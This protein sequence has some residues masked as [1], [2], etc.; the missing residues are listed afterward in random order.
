MRI[1][2]AT[3]VFPPAIG[4]PAKYAKNIHEELVRRGLERSLPIG[5]RHIIYFLRA[6]P[7]ALRA[8]VIFAL[9]TWS[10]GLPALFLAKILRKKFMVRIGGEFLW[11]KYV[12]RTKEEIRLS[13]FYKEKHPLDFKERVTLQGTR[14]LTRQADA[15]LFTTLWLARIWQEPYGLVSSK[16]HILENEYPAREEGI[17]PRAR[18]FVY[19]GRHM[20]LKNGERLRRV[21]ARVKEKHP[22]IELDTRELPA[23]ANNE[24]IAQEINLS[25]ST[26]SWHLDK[27][28][29]AG[30]LTKQREGRKSFFTL[31]SPHEA[32]QLL[33]SF[34]QSFLDQAVDNFVELAQSLAG[35]AAHE[36]TRHA[37]NSDN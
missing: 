12:E 29:S 5:A 21:F 20:T 37:P 15:L 31:A 24:R 26:T 16:V 27:L 7:A 13:D 28:V 14:Y 8:D 33:V 4:G 30:V 32:R 23:K 1:L 25:P 11:E 19:V 17:S 18:S 36:Q 6:F 2:I 35:P 3:G 9:D 22:D 34:K 10:T